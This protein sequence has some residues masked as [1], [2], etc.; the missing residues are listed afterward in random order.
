MPRRRHAHRADHRHLDLRAV[1]ETDQGRAEIAG[2]IFGS[3]TTTIIRCRINN[4]TG[5]GVNLV[6]SSGARA[7]VKDSIITDNAGGFNI[8]G[9]GGVQNTGISE[10]TFYDNNP[11]FGIQ[12]S[13]P[14]NLFVTA[15]RIS[16]A[17][18]AVNAIGGASVTSF[19]DN[20]TN[21]AFT[22][23]ATINLK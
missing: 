8:A 5:N 3:G 23:T 7:I 17:P 1:S 14:S 22:P 6:G 18:T 21:G 4:F 20:G 15:N 16:A 19:G 10:G 2:A 9:A 12:V 13:A 11:S